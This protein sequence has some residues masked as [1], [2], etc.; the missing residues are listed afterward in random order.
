MEGAVGMAKRNRMKDI[1][2]ETGVSI[3]TVSR[4]I[5]NKPD[6]NPE[7]RDRILDAIERHQYESRQPPHGATGTTL[8]G[9][10]NDFRKYSLPSHYV[11][12]LLAG[13]QSR[14]SDHAYNVTMIDSAAIQKEMRWPGRYEIFENL[15][16]VVW[17]MPIF[18]S[19]HDEFLRQRGLP[20][21]VINNLREGVAAPLVESDNRTA[22]RQGVEYLVGMGHRRIGFVG[23][24]LD[25]ANM[26]DRYDGYLHQ[27]E[28][29]DL[30]VNHDWIIDDLAAVGTPNGIEGTWRL[31]GRRNLPTA[32]ICAN[33]SV[34]MGAY[35]VLKARGIRI[36]EDI[37]VL[38]FDDTPLS[39]VMQ[40]PITTFR[41][42]LV[43]MGERAVD[44]LMDLIHDPDAADPNAHALEP[45]T[46]IVR[47]SVR[48]CEPAA[49]PSP[50]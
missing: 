22:I 7:T 44:L 8:I 25:I 42:H 10:V 41:Q 11:S 3:A 20:Y 38:S 26:R 28:A 43:T 24:A 14:A 31:L 45:L 2:E 6:V 15:S 48:P 35:E 27:M 19:P 23:G 37:S 47:D 4:V 12:S 9:F 13:S 18:D 34:A 46:L 49:G 21:V 5:N 1:A 33:E 30:E 17:S 29:F 50:A 39:S 32:I 36:P 40:P 16:G